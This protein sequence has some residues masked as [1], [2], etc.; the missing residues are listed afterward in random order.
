MSIL[1]KI[2][3]FN[4][5]VCLIIQIS[6]ILYS[7]DGGGS[8][9]GGT[10]SKNPTFFN[11]NPLK[12]DDV[13][14]IIRQVVTEAVNRNTPITVVVID[15]GGNVLGAFEMT[16]APTTT[17]IG[18]Q[19]PD[20]ILQVPPSDRGLELMEV[21]SSLAA[22]SKAGA[23]GLFS[24]SG[25]A[26]STLTTS[27]V[28]QEHRPPGISFTPS[29]PVFGV[30]FS[31]LP[32]SDVISNSPLPLG[33]GADPGGVPL[34]KDGQ[35]VGAIGVEGVLEEVVIEGVVI[36]TP[37]YA[38]A[39]PSFSGA[40][41]LEE[42]I[43]VA[44]TRGFEAPGGIR[45]STVLLDGFRLP[46]ANVAPAENE[47]LIPFD[48]L[49]GRVI[50][51]E[52]PAFTFFDGVIRGT[53]NPSFGFALSTIRGLDVRITVDSAGNN[54]FPIM[55]SA[56]GGLTVE[57]VETIVG[58]AV[59]RSY[60]TRSALRQ[61]KGSFAQVNI[62]VV[63]EN[64]V[65]LG[66]V[67]IPDAPF[68]GFDVSAQKARTASFF[69][70]PTAGAELINAGFGDFVQAAT[71]DDLTFDG[72]IVYS[73]RAIAFLSVPF[74]PDGI[75]GTMAAPFSRDIS[76]WSPFNDGLQLELIM[77]ALVSILT[78]GPIQ[79]C[80]P[81]E[82]LES[83]ISIFPGAFPL[84]KG[85]VFVGAIGVSGDG[86]QENDLVAVSGSVGFEAPNQIRS[87]QIFVRGAR[88]PWARFPRNPEIINKDGQ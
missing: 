62:T 71:D 60:R 33:L 49:P 86:I 66:Y 50:P 74:L 82:G 73:S 28:I 52:L 27:D 39:P 55:G 65:I 21:P 16:G 4:F 37:R 1:R 46:F 88:L 31:N 41:P 54:R 84:Y 35:S 75:D 77:D 26:F 24:T 12:A 76:I 47:V 23:A 13:I 53:P 67:G 18:S 25:N 30:Q 80:T 56:S 48:E 20:R 45:S 58:Q 44:G 6:L 69:A 22:I 61:P 2:L 64:G 78:G 36:E 70:N 57:D 5:V 59:E 63:D 7:C 72:S 29:G 43:A 17:L 15:R 83:G 68:E 3:K 10:N 81:I 42:I 11:T 32:C 38:L 8:N 51:I 14:L 34:Y 85:D 9:G 19:N 79:P 40:K 87:D